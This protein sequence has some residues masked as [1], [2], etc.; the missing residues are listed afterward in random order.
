M[1]RIISLLFVTLFFSFSSQSFAESAC[2]AGKGA[3]SGDEI[4]ACIQQEAEGGMWLQVAFKNSTKQETALALGV[5]QFMFKQD[6]SDKALELVE[7]K[8]AG[9]RLL[10]GINY[11]LNV[12]SMFFFAAVY[13]FLILKSLSNGA[14]K[15]FVMGWNVFP[16]SMLTFIIAIAVVTGNFTIFIKIAFAVVV[17]M[18][19]AMLYG[20]SI[21]SHLASDTSGVATR[22]NSH[23]QEFAQEMVYGAIEWHIQDIT[24]RKGMLVETGNLEN[25]L[26]GVVLKDKEFLKCLRDEP[27]KPLGKSNNKYY[28]ASD[29][30]KTQYCGAN[31]LGYQTYR[32]GHIKD[33]KDSNESSVVIAKFIANQPQ[34]R[35]AA[36]EIVANVCGSVYQQHQDLIKDYNSI[37]LDLKPNGFIL[38]GQDDIVP[39]LKNANVT[40]TDVM[41]AK[42]DALVSEFAVFSYTEMLKNSNKVDNKFDQHV[43]FDDM[44]QNFQIGAEYKKAYEA[45]GM[46]VIDIKMVNDVAI[47]KS[48][49]QQALSLE[50][51]LDIFGGSGTNVTFGINE[52]YA[53]LKPQVNM[54]AEIIK[55]LDGIAGNALSDLGLQYADCFESNGRCSSGV[56]NFVSPLIETSQTIMPWLASAYTFSLMAK[57]YYKNKLDAA[58]SNDPNRDSLQASERFYAGLGTTFIGM[59]LVLAFAFL[60]LFKV[61]ILDY[62]NLLMKGFMMPIIMPFAFGYALI[63]ST[64]SKMFKDDSDSLTDLMKQ[65]GV[66]DVMF[67]LPLV[68]I[69][70]L[71]GL[72]VMTVAM[73]ISSLILASMFG[74]FAADNAGAGTLTLALKAIFF[75]IM[76]LLSYLASFVIGMQVA[77]KSTEK[78]I[79]ELCGNAAKFDDAVGETVAKAKS[80]I[81]KAG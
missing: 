6:Y 14:T 43:S 45:A 3:L 57:T 68:V 79:D 29:I 55:M 35:N 25:T 4:A 60:F 80:I 74:G 49:L 8:D 21:F 22:L 33:L 77:F 9:S 34:Y 75:V 81:S 64:Y 51:N 58:A 71:I 31:E 72:C 13:A 42:L 61:L 19:F 37:C 66:F 54:N 24:A 63:M 69:G 44:F 15:G 17:L 16:F 50:E 48:K 12:F 36:D 46:K 7:K 56:V 65:Y 70:F 53:S 28:Q 59:M 5:I 52:Y 18:A 32:I 73:F 47:K 62:S 2:Q 23:S 40:D 38:V 10:D 67:R 76:Y 41:K 30:E 78:A 1:K 11:V 26:H 39:T 27:K 20:V